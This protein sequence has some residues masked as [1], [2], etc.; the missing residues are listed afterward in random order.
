MMFQEDKYN[1]TF[2]SILRE[3]MDCHPKTKK[4]TTQKELAEYAGIRPQTVSLYKNGATQPTPDT[5]VKISKY[6]GVSVDYLLTGI[7][8]ENKKNNEE[9][10]LS[11]D[12]IIMLKIAKNTSANEDLVNVIDVLDELLSDRDFYVF[13]E[14]L[15]YETDIIRELQRQGRDKLNEKYPDLNIIGYHLWWLKTFIEEFINSELIKRGLRL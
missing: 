12:A 3:L 9:L 7:S 8:S 6:F 10:G 2:P 13:L 14:D 11:E 4:R 5:L 15:S 1:D